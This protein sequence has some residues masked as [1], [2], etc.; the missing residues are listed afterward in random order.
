[1]KYQHQI[2]ETDCGSR[3][4]AAQKLRARRQAGG[5]FWLRPVDKL[6]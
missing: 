1:M 6:A 4:I 2:D 3:C 5:G